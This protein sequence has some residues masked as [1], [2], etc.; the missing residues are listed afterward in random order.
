MNDAMRLLDN[1]WK[2]QIFKNALGSYTGVAKRYGKKII[3]DHF[4]VDEL[5]T[6]LA[7][8]V[9]KTGDYK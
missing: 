9:N 7:D 4:T 3:T 8:K 5:M 6:A 2:V 1:G